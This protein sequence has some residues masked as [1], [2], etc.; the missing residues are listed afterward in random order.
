MI[1]YRI[2]TFDKK[3]NKTSG[4][5]LSF[6]FY[7]ICE[8]LQIEDKFFL[9][10]KNMYPEKKFYSEMAEKINSRSFLPGIDE[11]TG[12]DFITVWGMLSNIPKP[13][14]WCYP[15][16]KNTPTYCLYPEEIFYEEILFLIQKAEHLI[17][18]NWHRGDDYFFVVKKYKINENSKNILYSDC[19]QAV[20][21]ENEYKKQEEYE[22]IWD[23][24]P[25]E[26]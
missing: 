5:Y 13:P 2:E 20:I 24:K 11:K 3:E 21:T 4:G 26:D 1:Y 8:I 16:H 23:F 19:Y 18:T 14:T 7:V 6:L 10:S 25:K 17:K 12:M 9:L 22:S 15:T